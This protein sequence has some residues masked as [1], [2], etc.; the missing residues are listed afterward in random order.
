[1]PREIVLVRHGETEWAREE[2]HTGRTDVPLTGEGRREAEVLG[3]RLA[4]HT[5]ALV[6]TSPL[7]RAVDTCR[8][9][10]LG[11]AAEVRQDLAEWDYG[12]YEG[13]TTPEI[14]AEAPGWSLWRDGCPGGE[15]VADVG[16]RADRVIAELRPLAG[17]AA[18]FAHGHLLRVLA[19]R[20]VGM[21]AEAGGAL[22]LSTATI[23]ILGY[24][25]DSPVIWLWNDEGRFGLPDL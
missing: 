14:R 20:W 11:A 15:T 13:R 10:G 5:F 19:A 17:D 3:R 6:L 12:C 23:S 22:G 21:P 24:E 4:G 1:V 8:L 7:R 2:R 25:H 9:A 16:R 18:V